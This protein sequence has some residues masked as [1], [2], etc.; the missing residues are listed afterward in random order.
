MPITPIVW[1]GR[2][3]LFWLKVVKQNQPN[4]PLLT[5]TASTSDIASMQVSDLNKFQNQSAQSSSGQYSVP[6]AA[7][8]CWTEFYNGS[9][10][11]TKT[12]DVNQPTKLG[13]FA[14]TGTY[15][16]ESCRNLIRIVPAQFSQTAAR[17][18]GLTFTLPDDALMLAITVAG[19][20]DYQGG[21]I[22]H[23]THSLPI[24]IDD[25]Y[26]RST[27]ELHGGLT[28]VSGSAQADFRLLSALDRPSLRR[29]FSPSITPPYAGGYLGGTFAISYTESAGAPPSYQDSLFTYSWQ[30]RWV[31]PQPWLPAPWA[32]CAPFIYEDRRHLFY[33]VTTEQWVPLR[34]IGG[35]G[36]L[37]AYAGSGSTDTTIQPLILRQPVITPTPGQ[38][39][40]INASAGDPAAVQRYL[41]QETGLAAALPTQLDISYQGQLITPIGSLATII[42]RDDSDGAGE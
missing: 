5:T 22:L 29:S 37:S 13:A 24:R 33:V 10:Q 23:N 31:E 35:F 32:W 12:S 11:P 30:P 19:P 18:F 14:P 36:M 41:A 1:N 8:L 38:I 42:T 25:I 2:L 16:L 7:V 6:A 27:A 26:L 21:F 28:G 15:S 39:L 9:W 3:F 20:V 40:A 34:G 17:L 4:S